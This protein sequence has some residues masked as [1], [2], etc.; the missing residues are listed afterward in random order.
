VW[1]VAKRRGAWPPSVVFQVYELGIEQVID[2]K[3]TDQN[4]VLSVLTACTPR[5]LG[6]PHLRLRRQRDRNQSLKCWEGCVR[7][8]ITNKHPIPP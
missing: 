1:G 2:K 8:K 4:Y 5:Q 6:A 3:C 7:L